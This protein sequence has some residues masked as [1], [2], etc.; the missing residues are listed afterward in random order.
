MSVNFASEPDRF[1]RAFLAAVVVEMIAVAAFAFAPSPPPTVPPSVVQLQVIQPAPIPVA[2]PP[3]PKPPPPQPTRPTPPVPVTP[4]L[5][6][7]PPPQPHHPAMHSHPRHIVQPPPPPQPAPP[8]P[9]PPAP[10]TAAPPP[11]PVAAQTVM[12]RYISQVRA[13]VLSNLVVPQ[14]LI[15]AGLEGDCILQFTLGPDGTILSAS[16]VSPSGLKPVNEAAIDALRASHFPAFFPGM[17]D[18]PHVFSLPV[19]VSGDAQ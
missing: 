3:P 13:I 2:K 1:G 5:P 12:S 10:M 7:P 16:I 17:P 14:Q 11:S 8:V 19:H 15:D 18:Q 6:V 9:E 4:P